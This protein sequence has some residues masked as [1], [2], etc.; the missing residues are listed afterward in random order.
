MCGLPDQI[1]TRCRCPLE[2]PATPRPLRKY[3]EDGASVCTSCP[4]GKYSN[5]QGRSTCNQCIAPE[6]SL[7]AAIKCESC[8]LGKRS[9]TTG[10]SDCSQCDAA[11]YFSRVGDS[12]EC[13]CS[14]DYYLAINVCLRCPMG[15]AK[16]L[17]SNSQACL[18]CPDHLTLW[19]SDCVCAENT[20]TGLARDADDFPME[21]S[22]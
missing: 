15:T 11:K 12:S 10:S 5:A 3:S 13:A 2:R 4:A 9:V 14:P 19:N 21:C 8:S 16:R 18:P 22:A 6:Y 7:Q 17:T 20:A 1:V